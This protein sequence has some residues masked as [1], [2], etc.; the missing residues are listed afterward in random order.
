MEKKK[1]LRPRNLISL[2]F[3]QRTLYISA[4]PTG[5]T[6]YVEG[7]PTE[8]KNKTY[9]ATE[10]T[11]QDFMGYDMKPVDRSD[12]EEVIMQMPDDLFHAFCKNFGLEEKK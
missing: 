11:F 7:L 6:A 8:Y 12:I 3:W 2:L 1:H 5:T 4:K 9:D 10:Q